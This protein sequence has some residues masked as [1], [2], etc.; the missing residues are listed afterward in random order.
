MH[1]GFDKTMQRVWK[2]EWADMMAVKLYSDHTHIEYVSPAGGSEH[3]PTPSR[4]HALYMCL[5]R[6]HL[7]DGTS[8]IVWNKNLTLTFLFSELKK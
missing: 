1:S 3:T 6:V 5:I 8:L 4:T 7:M 2:L